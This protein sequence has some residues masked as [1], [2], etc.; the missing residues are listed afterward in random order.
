M[1]EKKRQKVNQDVS[2]DSLTDDQN[3]HSDHSDHI[4][5]A[6]IELMLK[7]FANDMKGAMKEVRD[8]VTALKETIAGL[9]DEN[10]KLRQTVQLSHDNERMREEEMETLRQTVNEQANEITDLKQYLR[11]NNLKIYGLPEEGEGE[12]ESDAETARNVIRLC[13]DKLGIDLQE[14]DIDIAHRLKKNSEDKARSIIV[15]FVR[16]TV[17]NQVIGLRKKLKKT[18]IVIADDLC[19]E[20]ARMF[21][22][23]RRVV[24]RD[25]WSTGGKILLKIGG[26]ITPVI[27]ENFC[28]LMREVGGETEVDMEVRRERGSDGETGPLAPGGRDRDSGT[29]QRGSRRPWSQ[30]W[31]RPQRP[32]RPRGFGRG[33]L[34]GRGRGRGRGWGNRNGTKV[35]GLRDAWDDDDMI[36]NPEDY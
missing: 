4:S 15:R 3:D 1:A 24:G 14:N 22:S 6:R 21:H 8:D 5:E 23:L 28:S 7:G 32:Q 35:G 2:S 19:P 34:R 33:D 20:N 31:P 11:S 30:P 10:E 36:I 9:K 29:M 25:V 16:R 26:S 27:K 18:G 12:W 13:K 17:R